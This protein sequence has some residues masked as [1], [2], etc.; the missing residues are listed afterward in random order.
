MLRLLFVGAAA[1]LVGGCHYQPT[2]VPMAGDRSTIVLLAGNW[3]GTYRGTQTDRSGSITF[4]IRS[5]A[6]SAFGDVLMET[7]PGAPRITAADA[8]TIH[9]LHARSPQLLAIKFVAIYGGDIEGA[10][11][12]YN[13]PD[14][15]CIVTTRFTGRVVGDSISGTFMTRGALVGP[16]TGVW[17]VKR[18]K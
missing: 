5:N 17:A 1:L 11:E 2:P 16:Q 6:D 15:D 18:T 9:K 4:T 14:C 7:P 12:P 13:A 3:I 8:P 10:L